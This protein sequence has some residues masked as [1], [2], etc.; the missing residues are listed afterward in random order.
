MSSDPREL[1]CRYLGACIAASQ[2]EP[3]IRGPG[4]MHRTAEDSVPRADARKMILIKNGE[5]HGLTISP[6]TGRLLLEL[7]FR[8]RPLS[9]GPF[10]KLNPH[11]C[12]INHSRPLLGASCM[13][14]HK[15]TAPRSVAI[16]IRIHR[17]N[18][19]FPRAE[20]RRWAI[21]VPNPE[22]RICILVK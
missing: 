15:N 16:F 12:D 14:C 1:C 5:P 6:L 19:P 4:L 2:G 3:L 18:S 17:Q 11:H 7:L 20:Q 8:S 21:R 22:G 13:T 9:C 10:R